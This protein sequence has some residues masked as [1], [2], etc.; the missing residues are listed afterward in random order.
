MLPV[1]VSA[2]HLLDHCSGNSGSGQNT[3]SGYGSSQGTGSGYGSNT[4]TG[5]GYDQGTG[6]GYHHTGTGHHHS[7]SGHPSTGSSGGA[8]RTGAGDV[9]EISGGDGSWTAGHNKNATPTGEY[10]AT[11]DN[12]GIGQKIKDAL[13]HR[14]EELRY[15]CF[16][17]ECKC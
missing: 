11:G 8:Y 1:M 7:G 3:G 14:W 12:K 16:A 2:K 15:T 6:G 17:P 9:S 13:L 5:S 4:G 10:G